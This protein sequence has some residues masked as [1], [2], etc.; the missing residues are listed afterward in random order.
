MNTIQVK[1]GTAT[2]VLG[3]GEPGF[4]TSTKKLYV[5]DGAANYGVIMDSLLNAYSVIYADVD[6]TPAA[7]TVGA[8]TLVGR[9][10]SGG[11]AALTAAEILTLIGVESGADV[12]DAANVDAAGATMN[13]DTDVSGNSWIVDED[14]M[15]SDLATKVPTQQSVKAYVDGSVVG[16]YDYQGGYDASTNTP[17]LDAAPSGILKSD[18][19]TV[20]VAGNFFTEAVEVGDVIVANKDNPTAL[21]DWT[22]VNKNIDVATTA[23]PGIVE[24]ATDGE[25]AS[26]VVVQG[27]DSR[28]SDARTPSAHAST[29]IT[30]AADEVDGDKI[31]I[32]WNPSNYTPATTP[33]EVDNVDNLVAHLYGIDQALATLGATAWTGL[34][35]TP[36]AIDVH[37]IVRGDA[38]G[39]A[40][41]MVSF[42]STYLEASPTN[43]EGNKAPTSDWA[44]DHNAAVTGVHG[45][46]A[47]NLLNSGSVI[48]GGTWS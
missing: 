13:T 42:A 35:D 19:Y 14:D 45:A 32:D 21:G 2:S 16:L 8:S 46:G 39:A 28:L 23:T 26:G 27:N 11:I 1:R 29:H 37:Y 15:V 3:A 34:T 33:A 18:V 47:E 22:R 38:A 36:A 43:G 17:D 10:S 12:T 31:D 44:F 40:L 7:L 30:G 6:D 24:L 48:D 9:K 25:S 4:N 20:T 41:E 5:G